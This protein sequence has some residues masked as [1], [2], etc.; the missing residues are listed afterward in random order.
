MNLKIC[1]WSESEI[2]FK[3]VESAHE[4]RNLGDLVTAS[5]YEEFFLVL[6]N[7]EVKLLTFLVCGA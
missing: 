5:E 2:S 1:Y 6:L 3:I 7:G 4:N